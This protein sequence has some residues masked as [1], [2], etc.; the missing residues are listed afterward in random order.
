MKLT[1]RQKHDILPHIQAAV[2]GIIDSWESQRQIEF[3]LDAEIDEMNPG[4]E[5]LAI[6]ADKG[7]DIT[8][9]QVQEYID[10]CRII[11]EC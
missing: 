6:G 1:S 7:T 11:E 9:D 2:Q 3:L 10:G 5:D 4:L 8:I